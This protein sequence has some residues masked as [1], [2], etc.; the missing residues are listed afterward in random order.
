MRWLVSAWLALKV[1]P[2]WG[3]AE[4]CL[5]HHWLDPQYA[6]ELHF[7][8]VAMLAVVGALAAVAITLRL[9]RSRRC[10]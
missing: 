1:T 5:H 9:R 3:D 2:V 4:E 8:L 6:S 7:Q 10:G